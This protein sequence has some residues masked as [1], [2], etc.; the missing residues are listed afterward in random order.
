[1]ESILNHLEHSE[2]AC[3]DAQIDLADIVGER[4]ASDCIKL[5]QSSH[6]TAAL[7]KDR[8]ISEGE[9]TNEISNGAL[10]NDVPLLSRL[11]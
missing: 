5:W 8:T 2:A 11:K 9:K 3:P 6:T 7:L 10:E 1:M 4:A